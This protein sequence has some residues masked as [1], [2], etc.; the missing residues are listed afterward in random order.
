MK[1]FALR[2]VEIILLPLTFISAAWSRLLATAGWK[3]AVVSEK[4]FMMFGVLPVRD[5][6]TEPLVAPARHLKFPLDKDRLLPGIDMNVDVQLQILNSF[7]Y[8][9]EFKRFPLTRPNGGERKFFFNNGS[10]M[11]G[12][13]E[14]LY[15]II[16]HFK[17][18]KLIEIG[19]G[20]STLIAIEA[21]RENFREQPSHSIE[22]ICVE[23]FLQPWLEK[24]SAKIIREKVEDL[25][26]SIF[27]SLSANDILFIDS[28]HIIRPQGDV[29]FEYLELLPLL[30]PGVIVHVHD[31]FTPKDYLHD[32]IYKEHL[33][34]NEQY[35]FEAFLSMNKEFEI[36]GA[37][38]YLSH[39]HRQLFS[40]KCPIFAQQQGREPGAFWIRRK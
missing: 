39:H 7:S 14:Y 3:N 32:W 34:W 31:I 20:N 38:N 10:Y 35:I 11:S 29:L 24:T 28:S 15:S 13:A 18:R 1:L 12:D 19:S 6:Y 25:D 22:H 21:I 40:S 4:V 26:K 23:P 36:I 2:V 8:A 5:Y 16:R 17:P 30:K 37:V 27:Q 33:M 9:D